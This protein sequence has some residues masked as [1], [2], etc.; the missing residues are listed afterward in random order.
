M[1][2][3]GPEE[4]TRAREI[5]D[6][7]NKSFF[8]HGDAVSRSQA[9]SHELKIAPDDEVLEDLIWKAYLGIES[10]MQLREPFHPLQV[11][12]LLMIWKSVT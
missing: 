8:S 3:T 5:A 12:Q 7:L 1:H 6:N 4:K 10:Y 9:R 2:M 11:Y